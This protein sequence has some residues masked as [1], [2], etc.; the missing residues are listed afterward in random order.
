M[1]SHNVSGQRL[2]LSQ[3]RY[4]AIQHLV[5]ST[6]I[7]ITTSSFEV[8]QLQNVEQTIEIATLSLIA[9]KSMFVV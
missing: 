9:I 6:S 8:F 1:S 4:S 7:K 3:Y 5:H 2:R